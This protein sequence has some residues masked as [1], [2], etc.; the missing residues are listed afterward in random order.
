MGGRKCYDYL[1]GYE[2]VCAW[3]NHQEVLAGGDVTWERRFAKNNKTYQLFDSQMK[4][5]DGSLSKMEIFIDITERKQAE[6]ELKESESRFRTLY[7]TMAQGVVYQDAKGRILRANQAAERMLGL[8][9][10][11]MQG[12]ASMFSRW[13]AVREDGSPFPD[14]EHPA[15]IALR[16]GK[17][18]H[19]VTMGIAHHDDEDYRWVIIDAIPQEE[20][21]EGVVYTTF[22]DITER[23]QAEVRQKELVEQLSQAQKMESVGRLAGGGGPR[24]Q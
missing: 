17:P 1:H 24:L 15:M 7:S 22:S 11:Q 8:S 12:Q 16:T 9:P 19:G 20:G 3:C 10:D 14:D 23:K 2:E 21:G 4:N 6:A 5:D 13:R 18:V